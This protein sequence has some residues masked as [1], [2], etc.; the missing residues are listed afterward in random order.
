M[1]YVSDSDAVTVPLASRAFDRLWLGFRPATL[2]S[3]QHMFRLFMAFLVVLDL[4]LHQ[5]SRMDILAFMKYLS[6]SGMSPDNIVNHWTAVRSLAIIY[7]IDTSPFH[8][9]RIPL[10]VK[11]LK[12]NRRFQPKTTFGVDEHLLLSM[13]TV[14]QHLSNPL[15][16][17]ALYLFCFFSF[18]R[19]SNMLPHAVNAS[20]LPDNFVL[21]FFF[22]ILGLRSS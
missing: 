15:V 11:S 12:I 3:Y 4:S 18:L 8:D 21:V 14:S 7:A 19:L 20:I 6:E 22:Q 17:T 2:A 16:F 5:I 1:S 9:N 13:I 10:F